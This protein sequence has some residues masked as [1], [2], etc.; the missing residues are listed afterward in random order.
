MRIERCR[1]PFVAQFH[2]FSPKFYLNRQ[3]PINRAVTAS[4]LRSGVCVAQLSLGFARV[5]AGR[6]HGVASYQFWARTL[7]AICRRSIDFNLGSRRCRF[8]R[9][10]PPLSPSSLRLSRACRPSPAHRHESA[11]LGSGLVFAR[12][13]VPRRRR[14][15]RPFLILG[16]PGWAAPPCVHHKSDDA[17][18][19]VRTTGEGR[20]HDAIPHPRVRACGG[21]G[22]VQ[23]RRRPRRHDQRRRRDQSRR[24]PLRQRHCRRDRRVRSAAA[25]ARSPK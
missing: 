1:D 23:T 4:P 13:F 24:D 6:V 8:A 20:P 10:R 15:Q 9:R 12:F 17:L 7:C 11:T 21:P 5:A 18:P 2:A 3:R 22:A 19:P 14:E 25:K 16:R